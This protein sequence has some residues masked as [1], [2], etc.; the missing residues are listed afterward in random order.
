[1]ILF[2]RFQREKV[3]GARPR[4]TVVERHNPPR[5]ALFP[6]FRICLKKIVEDLPN[7]IWVRLCN[8]QLTRSAPSIVSQWPSNAGDEDCAQEP[9]GNYLHP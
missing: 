4:P 2:A 9:S 8:P 1:M 3:A 5:M 6:Q 7:F